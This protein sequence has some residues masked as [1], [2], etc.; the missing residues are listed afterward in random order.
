MTKQNNSND[1]EYVLG[2]KHY[3]LDAACGS[4]HLLL[5]TER[6]H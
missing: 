2:T 4:G 6:R 3:G 1:G 5:E